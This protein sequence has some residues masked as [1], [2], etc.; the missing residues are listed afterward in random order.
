MGI[1]HNLNSVDST[2][3]IDTHPLSPGKFHAHLGILLI[4]VVSLVPVR[5]GHDALP[6]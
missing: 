4:V 1:T 2:N 6:L 3:P 5:V